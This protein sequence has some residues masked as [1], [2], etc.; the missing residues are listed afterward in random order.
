MAVS[1]KPKLSPPWYT[2]AKELAMLFQYDD[3]VEVAD[4]IDIDQT[5]V[6]EVNA[7]EDKFEALRL[8]IP[9]KKTFGNVIVNIEVQHVRDKMVPLPED[10]FKVAFRNNP[11]ATVVNR[12]AS[13]ITPSQTFVM[14]KK[15]V[16]QFF[17]DDI[18]D[19]HGNKSTLYEDIA[20]DVFPNAGVY[21]CTD[22]K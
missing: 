7:P 15:E 10:V 16:V 1:M 3:E 20:R 4:R 18:S 19:Y 9:D 5:I 11:V 22:N 13:E 17:N 6:V 12:Q 8:L 21:F 14:F 2:F